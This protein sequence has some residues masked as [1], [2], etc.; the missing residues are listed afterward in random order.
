MDRAGAV[1]G[2]SGRGRGGARRGRVGA[3]RVAGAVAVLT[4]VLV[5]GCGEGAAPPLPPPARTVAVEMREYRF[6]WRPPTTPGRVVLHIRNAG[7]LSHDLVLTQ[8]PEDLPPILEQLRGDV[9]RNATNVANLPPRPP[10]D[11][12][13]F[14]VDLAP[15]R[16]AIVCFVLDPDG[17]QHGRK[18]MAAEFRV[19]KPRR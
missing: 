14:A 18:G 19:E 17:L 6:V 8:L 15:G 12:T 2:A 13:A 3:P 7:K 10:G 16:Y 1:R 9:R 5:P 11:R 4:A